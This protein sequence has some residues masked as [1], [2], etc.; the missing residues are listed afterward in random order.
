MNEIL[1]ISREF[2]C[3]VDKVCYCYVI[4]K[5]CGALCWLMLERWW[6]HWSWTSEAP[7][8][9][10]QAPARLRLVKTS[11]KPSP[12]RFQHLLLLYSALRTVAG[13]SNHFQRE[14]LGTAFPKLFWQW[15]RRSQEF[16]SS[17]IIPLHFL[18]TRRDL[19]HN[20]QFAILYI[21]S[22]N[23]LVL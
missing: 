4:V 12:N 16:S 22:L 10:R 9:D 15:E 14:R 23:C 5:F 1:L 7:L 8:K 11:Q 21:I 2:G 6:A 3:S 20:S 13:G 17:L 19:R 18:W